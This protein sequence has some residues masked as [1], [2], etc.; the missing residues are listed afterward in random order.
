E[1]L[2]SNFQ[3]LRIPLD[4][5]IISLKDKPGHLRIYGRESLTSKFTQANIARRWQHFNF[6][7]ET[8]MAFNPE[9]FQ[10]AAG[11]VNYYNTENWTA[12]QITCDDEK[13]RILKVTTCVNS[14]VD[15]TLKNKEITL[16][17]N[18]EYIYLRV[19]VKSNIYTYSYSYNGVKWE[20]IPIE[21]YS[22]NL[23][24]DYIRGG[25]FF[26]GAF[27]GM[28]CQDTSGESIPADFDYFI[29]KSE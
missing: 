9:N 3:S 27:I 5:K 4:E 20:E 16:P 24:D 23:S 19:N 12:L 11:L 17:K 10:Q 25:G 28:Q 6:T 13:G 1:I 22:Y 21:F 8:K 2:N 15:Q 14:T 18:V 7:A 29:Y 26:T